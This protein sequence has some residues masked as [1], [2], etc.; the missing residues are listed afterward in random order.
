MALL[1]KTYKLSEVHGPL[2]EQ[3]YE[4]NF[5]AIGA[6][7]STLVKLRG[8]K[9][10]EE[11]YCIV[12]KNDCNELVGWSL[13]LIEHPLYTTDSKDDRLIFMWVEPKFRNNEYASQIVA[14]ALSKFPK[15]TLWFTPHDTASQRF[16]HK[17]RNAHSRVKLVGGL[18]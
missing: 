11:T 5:G 6:M 16:G 8:T 12:I 18:I 10:A 9:E 4:A 15:Y 7:Q 1:I 17:I 13:L 3:L 14:Y 2:Y